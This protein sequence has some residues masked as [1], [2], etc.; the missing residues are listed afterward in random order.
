MLL[1]A[2]DLGRTLKLFS[3]SVPCWYNTCSGYGKMIPCRMLACESRVF[4]SSIF[5]ILGDSIVDSGS[6]SSTMNPVTSR[7]FCVT[8][9]CAPTHEHSFEQA[10]TSLKP[11]AMATCRGKQALQTQRQHACT[12]HNRSE[13]YIQANTGRVTQESVLL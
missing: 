12:H 8:C 4:L 10:A 9:F 5:L 1:A 3:A 6:M 2:H 11:I 7:S 13:L